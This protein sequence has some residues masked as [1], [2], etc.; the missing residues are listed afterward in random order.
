[1]TARR[2]RPARG[3]ADALAAFVQTD[4]TGSLQRAAALVAVR[5]ASGAGLA[6]SILRVEIARRRW[7]LVAR[8]E[9]AAGLETVLDE[10][11]ERLRRELGAAAPDQLVVRPAEGQPACFVARAVADPSPRVPG[12]ALG[13]ALAGLADDGLRAR[14]ERFA[15][16]LGA[17]SP[18]SSA[19]RP[20]AR[21]D[22]GN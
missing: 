15:R 12:P 11:R 1:M 18:P 4:P 21:R 13:E 17:G 8:E 2:R 10:L 14:F 6:G 22:P 7:F 5:R 20:A 9:A 16:R 3:I 19:A